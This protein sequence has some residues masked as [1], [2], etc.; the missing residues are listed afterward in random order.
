ME[1]L[2]RVKKFEDLRKSIDTENAVSSSAHDNMEVEQQEVLKKFDSSILKK[3]EIKED[4]SYIPEREK[5]R[6]QDNENKIEDTFTNEYL[7]DFIREVREYNIQRGNRESE[8]TQVDILSQLNAANRAK[9]THYVKPIQE[10]PS[11][12]Y[13]SGLSREDIALE[14][15][16][17][18]QEETA[19]IQPSSLDEDIYA[20]TEMIIDHQSDVIEEQEIPV[21]QK[22]IIQPVYD[23]EN[24][25]AFEPIQTA[26]LP[27]E[28][29]HKKLME[30]TQQL[31]VQMDEYEE[32]LTDLSDGV[33]KNN[34]LLNFIL[35]FL[36][37]VLLV[38]IGFIGYYVWKGGGF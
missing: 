28:H 4:S 3:V 7:D 29:L 27:D 5:S 22:K 13:T 18:L 12:E 20:T 17:L 24:T 36:I 8:D 34:K 19:P 11:V 30:E 37:L 6:V 38:I 9:R 21:I 1:K 23:M 2:S 35:C 16:S 33:E 10:D 31:R 25:D 32:E 14:V 15:Q 26:P